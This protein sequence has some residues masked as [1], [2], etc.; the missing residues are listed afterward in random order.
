M[1]TTLRTPVSALSSLASSAAFRT[2][3]TVFAIATPLLYVVC[4]MQNLPLFT[5]HPGT[6]R[7]DFGW[8]PAVRDEGPAMYWYGW[9]ASTLLGAAVLGLLATLL[10]A[11][12]MRRV[13]LALV[14]IVPLAMLPILIYSL[15]FFWRW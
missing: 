3:A 13:P 4:D 7:V 2:F 11:N 5:Y 15:K 14:W 1:S 10:P 12:M 6:D 8:A 9:T